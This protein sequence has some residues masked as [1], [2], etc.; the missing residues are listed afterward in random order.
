MSSLKLGVGTG[1]GAKALTQPLAQKGALNAQMDST[2]EEHTRT[3]ESVVRGTQ[4][5]TSG[6]HS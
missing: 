5:F 6:L 3:E 4:F 2:N 1:V